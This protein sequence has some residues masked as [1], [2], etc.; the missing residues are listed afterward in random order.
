MHSLAAKMSP[1]Q[2]SNAVGAALKALCNT[3]PSTGVFEQAH[4]PEPDYYTTTP[5]R[6]SA[7]IRFDGVVKDDWGLYR[8]LPEPYNSPSDLRYVIRIYHVLYAPAEESTSDTDSFIYAQQKVTEGFDAFY[9]AMREDTT[10]N[11]LIMDTIFNG[12]IAGPLRDPR[13][14]ED[15]F[16]ME[17]VLITSLY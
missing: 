15:F 12:A 7:F 9:V 3:N 16:G 13:T 10:L 6:P 2:A 17:I 8:E 14:S 11:G 1:L 5:G 4:Y